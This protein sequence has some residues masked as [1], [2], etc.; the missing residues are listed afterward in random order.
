MGLS[1]AHKR[2]AFG[3]ALARRST[4]YV[5]IRD[6]I[7]CFVMFIFNDKLE[8]NFLSANTGKGMSVVSGA[9]RICKRN[10]YHKICH[11]ETCPTAPFAISANASN[12]K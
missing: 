1:E 7:I 4:G 6:V 8:I 10:T 12:S 11:N 9:T 5:V 2:N 3:S